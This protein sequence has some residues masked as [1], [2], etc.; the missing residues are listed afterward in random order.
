MII[1]MLCISCTVM[2]NEHR[3]GSF[4]LDAGVI[5]QL[6]CIYTINRLYIAVHLKTLQWHHNGH[7]GVSNHRPHH[8]LLNRLFGRRS[9]KT[10]KPR[11]TGLCVGNSPGTGE[12]PAQMAS[13][14]ENVSIW[15]R[16]HSVLHTARQYRTPLSYA[17]SFGGT[18]K[19]ND[20]GIY[21]SLTRPSLVQIMACRP[22]ISKLLLD[23]C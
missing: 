2:F 11:V 14:A 6:L 10:S 19:T 15:W 1:F 5:L 20:R 18:I 4:F 8:C 12:F 17:V 21:T 3:L 13:N 9:K 23:L 7:D 22:F 16:Y